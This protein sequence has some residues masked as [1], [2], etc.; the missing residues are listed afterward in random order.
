MNHSDRLIAAG[1]AADDDPGEDITHL[2]PAE[3]VTKLSDVSFGEF[4]S[5]EASMDDL[6]RD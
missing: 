5:V 4:Y 6:K 2:T 1:R 3:M